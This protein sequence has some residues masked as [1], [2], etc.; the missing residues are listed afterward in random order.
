MKYYI[1]AMTRI[2]FFIFIIALGSCF[3][4]QSPTGMSAKPDPM[5]EE[6]F[7]DMIGQYEDK[8]RDN[9]QNPNAVI[10]LLGDLADKTLVDLGAGTGYFTFRLLPYTGKVVAVEIDERFVQYLSDRKSNLPDSLQTTLD[11]RLAT[12]EDPHLMPQ[13]AD[14]ILL[15]NTIIY[16]RDRVP[17]LSLL[18]KALKPNGKIVIIDFHKKPLKIGP[19]MELKLSTHTIISDLAAA[20]YTRL[21]IDHQALPYQYVISAVAH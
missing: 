14:V 18:K 19:P 9:W 7:S 5:K 4:A 1:R 11:I 13:E 2:V 10:T 16:I 8:S 12:P 21:E 17:Y 3:D 15:V 6:K 20:G